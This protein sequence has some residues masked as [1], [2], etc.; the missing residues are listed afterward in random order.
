MPF[1]VILITAIKDISFGNINFLVQVYDDSFVVMTY[2]VQKIIKKR[3][4]LT[5]WTCIQYHNF[6]NFCDMLESSWE[7]IKSSWN[8]FR[9]LPSP[10]TLLN[11]IT[12]IHVVSD[13]YT[14]FQLAFSLVE[15][16]KMYDVLNFAY[17]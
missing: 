3:K 9:T 16:F 5:K 6:I 4:K 15:Q 12:S 14:G 10:L 2:S 7:N 8:D 1:F 17:Q 11:K 13:I